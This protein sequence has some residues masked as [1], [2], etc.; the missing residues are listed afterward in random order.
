MNKELVVKKTAEVCEWWIDQRL[1]KI[2][3][4]SLLKTMSINPFLVP[5]IAGI[6]GLE[7]KPEIAE[8]LITGHLLTGYNTGFGKLVDEKLLPKVFGT[9]KLDP[10]YR[11]RSGLTP[12]CFDDI[13]HIVKKGDQ[14]TLLSL[15]A[16]RW[17]IQLGQAVNLNHSFAEIRERFG[18]KINNILV[19]CY[20]GTR[21]GLSD[22]Y[23]ILR[24]VNRGAKHDVEDLTDFVDVKAGLKFWEWLGDEPATQEWVL[25][26]FLVGLSNHRAQIQS[27]LKHFY[28]LV[29]SVDALSPIDSTPPPQD[30][31]WQSILQRINS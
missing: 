3:N 9:A 14:V 5:I 27:A 15:K 29:N 18:G 19:G 23:D 10:D 21:E 6:H 31:Q 28:K 4:P 8:Y 13:D 7:T 30:Y 26:G 1:K 12:A 22:K 2:R 16:G 24:G 25:E 17:T 20:Y 11:R